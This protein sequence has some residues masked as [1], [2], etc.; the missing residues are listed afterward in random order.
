[1]LLSQGYYLNA[2]AAALTWH[3]TS[4]SVLGLLS[5]RPSYICRAICIFHHSLLRCSRAHHMA[6][7]HVS[8]C[9][10]DCHIHNIFTMFSPFFP[11]C[12]TGIQYSHDRTHAQILAATTLNK[13]KVKLISIEHSKTTKVNQS[14]SEQQNIWMYIEANRAEHNKIL[15]FTMKSCN[16]MSR[17]QDFENI[18]VSQQQFIFF[19][20]KN[21]KFTN[22]QWSCWFWQK[23]TI[24]QKLVVYNKTLKY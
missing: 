1:M 4:V 15:C 14:S 17:S 13:V 5:V 11:H 19:A 9:F 8:F 3:N 18:S 7:V 23:L 10:S 24:L 16:F 20:E 12:Q 2:T 21:T 6:A 22:L